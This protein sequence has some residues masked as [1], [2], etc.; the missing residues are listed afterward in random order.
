MNVPSL[1]AI[2]AHLRVASDSTVED[3]LLAVYRDAAWD[4]VHAFTRYQWGILAEAP[5]SV[6]A[7]VLLLI[8]DLYE[9]REA[10]SSAVLHENKTVE[11]LLW[12]HRVF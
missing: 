11:R 6:V 7:A 12:P 1:T 8:G 10:Q 2:K 3:S 5:A 9:N 4:H